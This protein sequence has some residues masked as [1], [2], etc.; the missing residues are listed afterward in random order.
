MDKDKEFKWVII[1]LLFFA[2]SLGFLTAYAILDDR[3]ITQEDL[4][5]Y[6]RTEW[7]E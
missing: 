2:L 5:E 4:N 7:Y 3:P 1:I 6:E